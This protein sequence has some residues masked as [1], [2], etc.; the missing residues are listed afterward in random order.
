M[1][2][3]L[4]FGSLGVYFF[5]YETFVL[6][7]IFLILQVL[8]IKITSIQSGIQKDYLRCKDE[9][10]KQTKSV[11]NCLPLVSVF[12]LESMAFLRVATEREKEIAQHISINV[13][14]SWLSLISWG[15]AYLSFAAM[16]ACMFLLGKNLTYAFVVPASKM[17]ML[18]LY[19]TG[20]I[21]RATEAIFNTRVSIERIQRFLN[22]EEVHPI[23]PEGTSPRDKDWNGRGS[24]GLQ[25]QEPLS[26]ARDLPASNI[27]L[28]HAD[29]SW[30]DSADKA[31]AS[32]GHVFRL[33][34]VSLEAKTGQLVV[35]IGSVGSGKSSVLNAIFN[36]MQLLNPQASERF[37]DRDCMYLPQK[38]WI[39]NNS[40]KHNV[41]LDKR[42]DEQRFRRA[43][44]AAHLERDVDQMKDREATQAGKKG[45]KLSGGQRWRLAL[46]RAHYQE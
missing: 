27:L 25:D 36:E 14:R 24:E 12:G 32:Q 42:W 22:I 7:L 34:N 21:P 5:G 33:E 4:I 44:Q 30:N 28:R 46:A 40:L 31:R 17:L 6:L 11:L 8:A 19:T 39:L 29:V 2:N 38:P 23:W 15:S 18:L 9:R 37:V 43:L 26:A 1:A 20:C 41:V 45:E 10:T 35:L 3:I 16:I 13:K